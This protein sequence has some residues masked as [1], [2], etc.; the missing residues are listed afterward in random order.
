MTTVPGSTCSSKFSVLVLVL[1]M[2]TSVVGWDGI[3]V[4]P[5]GTDRIRVTP[6]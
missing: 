5:W 6:W 2:L 3:T 4:P 1:L